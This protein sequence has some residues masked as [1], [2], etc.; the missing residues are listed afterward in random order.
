MTQDEQIPAD[1]P[2]REHWDNI[3]RLRSIQGTIELARRGDKSAAKKLLKLF[4]YRGRAFLQN[5]AEFG[6]QY[7]ANEPALWEVVRY[8]FDC[9]DGI[10][11]GEKADK[12]LNLSTGRKGRRPDGAREIAQKVHIGFLVSQRI[13]AGMDLEQAAESVAASEHVSTSKA[14]KAYLTYRK[15]IQG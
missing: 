4:N 11:S 15:P 12:A 8:L 7:A 6:P 3:E 1:H 13:D 2:I 5:L 10:L 9:F 14:K